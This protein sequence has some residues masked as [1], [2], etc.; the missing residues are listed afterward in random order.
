MRE[1]KGLR[2]ALCTCSCASEPAGD[3][4]DSQNKAEP[5]IWGRPKGKSRG[6]QADAKPAGG[7]AP[8]RS[9]CP[10]EAARPCRCGSPAAALAP[11]ERRWGVGLG[12]EGGR[13]GGGGGGGGAAGGA[14]RGPRC[15]PAAP[16]VCVCVCVCVVNVAMGLAW[17]AGA[18]ADGM[19]TSPA[20]GPPRA[21]PARRRGP[22]TRRSRGP[23][24][25]TACLQTT[26]MGL[27]WRTQME[28]SDGGLGSSTGIEYSDGW[29]ELLSDRA[30]PT[31][32]LQA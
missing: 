17:W 19:G 1:D 21:W 7:T 11:H 15:A 14:R 28:D 25:G 30:R 32:D 22:K 23:G 3:N 26:R 18:A 27:G 16:P 20:R 5:I 6:L 2:K 8:T 4:S 31:R 9:S 29:D 13:G 24:R 10:D 12:C